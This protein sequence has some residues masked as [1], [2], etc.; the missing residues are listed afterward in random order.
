MS[1]FP[2]CTGHPLILLP[3]QYFCGQFVGMTESAIL[4]EETIH[5]TL[6]FIGPVIVVMLL[7][8]SVPIT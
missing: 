4:M 3:D 1:C 2:V 5:R 6:A 7:D 8:G